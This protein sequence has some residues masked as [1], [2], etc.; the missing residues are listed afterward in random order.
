M[1]Q[2]KRK[3]NRRRRNRRNRNRENKQNLPV[4]V[5][6]LPANL[7]D[8]GRD[9][10]NQI[11]HKLRDEV[12]LVERYLY[13]TVKLND[14]DGIRSALERKPS[15]IV[16]VRRSQA[17]AKDLSDIAWVY[18]TIKKLEEMD[19]TYKPKILHWEVIPQFGAPTVLPEDR[20]NLR[21]ADAVQADMWMNRSVRQFL[22]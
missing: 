21:H 1:G 6:V 5:C 14:L 10:P 19:P 4:F 2:Q 22:N 11:G 20:P 3:K 9:I 7:S 8:L 17:I 18:A 12:L 16:M 13:A 15:T